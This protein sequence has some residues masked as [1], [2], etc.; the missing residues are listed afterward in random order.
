MLAPD[1]RAAVEGFFQAWESASRRKQEHL[2]S[3]VPIAAMQQSA[4]DHEDPWVRRRCLG[5]LDHYAAE[6]SAAV[7]VKA[8]DDP[9]APVRDIALHGLACE[10]CRTA[11]LCVTDVTPKVVRVLESDPN[12]EVRFKAIPILRRLSSRDPAALAAITRAAELDADERVR[13]AATAILRGERPRRWSQFRRA[14][15]SRKAKAS[16]RHEPHDASE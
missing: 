12:P 5:F 8:L 7:F 16:R 11:E 15:A 1:T 14:A 4:V 3:M 10:Q 9:V 2:R 13:L 6:T